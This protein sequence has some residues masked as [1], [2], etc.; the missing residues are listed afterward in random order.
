MESNKSNVTVISTPNTPLINIITRTSG[1]PNG[2]AINRNS[3]LNQNYKNVRHIVCT[4]DKKSI[5]YIEKNG[6]KDYHFI[7]KDELIK[8]DKSL[9][10]NTGK[11]FPYNLY[12]NEMIKLV[13]EG[14]IIYLDDDDR[15][16]DN[17][18]LQQVVDLIKNADED[19]IIYWRLVYSN[20]KY[21]PIDMSEGKKPILTGIG[22]PCFTFN[23]KY[24]EHAI[25]DGWKCADFRLISKLHNIIPKKIW[26]PKNIIY[27]HSSGFGNRIDIK[28]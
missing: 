1:R 15:F 4:D 26:Y 17:T 25:W 19:T 7:N 12:F 11:R 28:N 21:L 13:D 18:C 20:G 6:V 2:F 14:W 10:P 8:K 5:L 22:S 23:V 3:I 24:K 9:N 27:I 16:V